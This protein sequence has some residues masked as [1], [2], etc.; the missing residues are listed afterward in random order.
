[1]KT[2]T[3]AYTAAGLCVAMAAISWDARAQAMD[4]RAAADSASTAGSVAQTGAITFEA[5]QQIDRMRTNPPVYIPPA[6]LNRCS[7]STSG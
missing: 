4:T 6:M 5:A 7:F 1:M 2:S 3:F